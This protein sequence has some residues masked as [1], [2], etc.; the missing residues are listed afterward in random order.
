MVVVI[1]CTLKS[2]GLMII[3]QKNL[4]LLATPKTFRVGKVAITFVE[5]ILYGEPTFY[6]ITHESLLLGE[7]NP[8]LK[9]LAHYNRSRLP[10]HTHKM[11]VIT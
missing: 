8:H 10:E 9:D 3:L 7:L 6:S 1:A 11:L 5:C 4:F 2:E